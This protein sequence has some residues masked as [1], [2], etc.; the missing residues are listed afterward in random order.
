MTEENS[1]SEFVE[2]FVRYQR[3]VFGYILTIVANVND[4][5]EIF[6][7]ASI[8]LWKKREEFNPNADFLPWACGVARQVARNQRAKKGRDRHC[9]SEPFLEQLA[10]AR[11]ERSE[12]LDSALKNLGDCLDRLSDD[13]RRLLELRYGGQYSI[14]EVSEQL[15][16]PP[17]AIYQRLHRLRQLLHDCVQFGLRREASS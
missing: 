2:L 10:I 1:T 3:A 7:E 15:N 4:A 8:V 11:S 14:K 9:F 5:D 6:Q 17:N 13:Q 12:W 16:Y